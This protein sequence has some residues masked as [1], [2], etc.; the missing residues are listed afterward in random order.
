MYS[1]IGV[2]EYHHK[3]HNSITV[4]LSHP[5]VVTRRG[6]KAQ[7]GG[8]SE[9]A[10]CDGRK[11]QGCSEAFSGAFQGEKTENLSR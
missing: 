2:D 9:G 11:R 7:A 4:F 5:E 6:W 8:E 10:L 3:G 1:A